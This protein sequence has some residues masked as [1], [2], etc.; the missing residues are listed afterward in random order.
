MH[1]E[2]TPLEIG[3][4]IIA[5]QKAVHSAPHGWPQ[6]AALSMFLGRVEVW[7]MHPHDRVWDL[8]YVLKKLIKDIE[9]QNK[10]GWGC[11]PRKEIEG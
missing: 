4:M 11:D 10:K 3:E 9:D 2:K 7:L 1:N 8:A 6:V 5:A